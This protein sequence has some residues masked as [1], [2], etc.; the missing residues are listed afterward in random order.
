MPRRDA[1]DGGFSLLEMLF[2]LGMSAVLGA[3]AT[4]MM[5]NALGSYRL[6]GD[7]KA[8]SNSVAMTKM[9][10]ASYFTQARL[11]VDLTS[12]YH[13]ETFQK[14]PAPGAWV[15]EGGTTNL[16]GSDTF[17]FGTLAAAPPSTQAVITQG[18]TGAEACRDV[19]GVVI[20]NTVCM[21]FNSRGIPIDWTGA[22]TGAG[23]L[24]V[25]DGAGVYGVTISATGNNLLWRSPVGT[26]SW[27]QQ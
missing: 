15:T 6:S 7:A 9:R 24:Y 5:G 12:G 13:I 4:P 2:V 1:A 22:P 14:T 11:Y 10:A 25:T 8:L 17:G 20:G 18:V 26:A 27:V 23:A 21:L 19:A 3:I 16:M